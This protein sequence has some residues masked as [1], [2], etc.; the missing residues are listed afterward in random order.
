MVA[1]SFSAREQEDARRRA[2][3]VGVTGIDFRTLDLRELEEHRD[4]LGLFDQIICFETIEH[5][6][7]DEGLVRS[8]AAMLEPGGRL[9]LTA[10]FES[11]HPLY[12][13][14][15]HPSP[16]EDGSHVRYGYSRQRLREIAESAGLEVASEGLI[17]GMVSQKL[18]DLMRRIKARFGRLAAWGA[19]LPLRPLVVLDAPLTRMLGY[20]HLSVALCAVKR[21]GG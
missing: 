3:V 12:S 19:V 6:T 18:T 8:L 10:P 7:D 2:S 17:S 15:R 20:P 14:E 5:L 16:V 1:A 13:E 9:L 4:S 11:H 21:P